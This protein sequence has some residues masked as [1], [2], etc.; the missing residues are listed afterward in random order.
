MYSAAVWVGPEKP[1]KTVKF[2]QA[3]S[4]EHAQNHWNVNAIRDTQEFFVR[5]VRYKIRYTKL[6]IN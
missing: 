5:R 6:A 1:A 2:C 3:V 4:T